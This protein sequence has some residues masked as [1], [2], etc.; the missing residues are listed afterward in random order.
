VAA[1]PVHFA[2]RNE[3]LQ[4][5]LLSK[6]VKKKIPYKIDRY[7]E[8]IYPASARVLV[9][10]ELIRSLRRS[11]FTQWQLLF[12]PD[13]WI[14]V[15]RKYMQDHHIDFIEESIAGKINFLLSRVYR[16]HRWQL[17]NPKRQRPRAT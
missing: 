11:V 13:D 2:F 12:C 8:I 16:P 10:E 4:R 15:Y 9:E 5:K 7:G 6:L 1:K 17:S 14:P 3:M